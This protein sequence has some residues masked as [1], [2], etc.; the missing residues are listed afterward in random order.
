MN[1]EKIEELIDKAL[2][3]GDF[4]KLVRLLDER[5]RLIKTSDLDPET[6]E[7][8]LERDENRLKKL[9]NMKKELL[10]TAFR[11]REYMKHLEER[12]NAQKGRSWGK[13]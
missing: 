13:G 11:S 7:K 9:E 5:E 8:I 2:E 10:A 4:E 3:E 6:A 1:I 12:R